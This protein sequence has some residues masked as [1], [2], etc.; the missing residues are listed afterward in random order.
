MSDAMIADQT[1][2]HYTLPFK[3][4]HG[5]I[6]RMHRDTYEK[7]MSLKPQRPKVVANEKRGLI[8][9]GAYVDPT[10]TARRLQALRADGF[11]GW[12]LGDRLGVSYEAVRQ[13]ARGRTRVLASTR[14]RVVELYE[15]L[16]GK[17]PE[18]FGVIQHSIDQCTTIARRQGYAPRA[19]WDSDTID[20]PKAV[21]DW[22]GRCGTRFGVAVHQREGIPVCEPCLKAYAGVLFPGFNGALLREVREKRGLSRT[23]LA[24]LA[25]D[26]TASTI[27]YWEGGRSTPERQGK[28]DRVLSVLDATYEDVCEEE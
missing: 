20:D 21:P 10:G 24:S 18:D 5:V 25:G 16:A 13:L 22:T 23:E 15:E 19:C 11:P 4:R 9:E 27:Q 17:T 26:I 7:V 1:G 28:L 6:S 14:L 12:L 8:G 2:V 3:V